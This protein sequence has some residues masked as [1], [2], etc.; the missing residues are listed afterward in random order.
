M[1][2]FVGYGLEDWDV[3]TIYNLLIEKAPRRSRNMSFAIQ[4]A[5]TPFW[6]RFWEKKGVTIYDI[7]LD[8]FAKQ[9]E[10]EY[11]RR[12]KPRRSTVGG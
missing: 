2:L 1:L 7:D 8:E 11:A 4:K 12:S 5:P 9:L 3:R 10:R 6:A